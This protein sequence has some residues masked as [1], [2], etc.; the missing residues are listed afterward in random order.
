MNPHPVAGWRG[1]SERGCYPR[2]FT[3]CGSCQ[4]RTWPQWGQCLVGPDLE[5]AKVAPWR[6]RGS[7]RLVPPP[8]TGM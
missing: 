1:I 4:G 7:R 8:P 6:Q 3:F 5:A 2:V